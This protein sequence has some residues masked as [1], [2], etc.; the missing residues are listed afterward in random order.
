MGM[1][2]D[3][4]RRRG[5]RIGLG[6][7]LAGSVLGALVLS[8]APLLAEQDV[9]LAFVRE[10][11][12]VSEWDRDRLLS[13]CGAVPV[14]VQD[15][16]YE[17]TKSFLACPLRFVL[18]N[19][20]G[21][22]ARDLAQEQFLFKAKDGYMRPAS[23]GKLLEQGGYLALGEAK[24]GAGHWQPIGRRQLDPGPYYV[25]WAGA[26]QSDPHV[27]PWPYQL[28]EIRVDAV[29]NAFPNTLPTGV[30]KGEPAWF[31][32]ELFRTQ[33]MACHAINGEGGKIGPDLNVPRSIV[34]YRPIAQIK[35]YVRDPQSF[36]YTTMPAHPGLGDEALDALVAYFEAM[37]ERKR[38]PHKAA[39]PGKASP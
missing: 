31:G 39:Q 30:P 10:G 6:L 12:P 29:E 7:G 20:F 23:G 2:R 27:Y 4:V 34:E 9:P 16:Y 3:R 18:E 17:T 28:V 15:P 35:D 21:V 11:K 14:V 19:G 26:D 1:G 37:K 33:C 5:R 32:F 36:R 22:S 13:D 25:V 24:G 8:A 38:D